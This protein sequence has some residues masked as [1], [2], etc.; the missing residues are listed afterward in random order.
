[1][2]ITIIPYEYIRKEHVM[3]KINYLC[4]I[5]FG[6]KR[7]ID[8]SNRDIVGKKQTTFYY[9]SIDTQMIRI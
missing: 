6:L 3:D 7:I 8:L 9:D 1:M 4:S 2:I 5:V